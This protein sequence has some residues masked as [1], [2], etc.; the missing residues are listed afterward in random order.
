MM[1]RIHRFLLSVGIAGQLLSPST[2]LRAQIGHQESARQ[3][4]LPD[5]PSHVQGAGSSTTPVQ[6][7]SRRIESDAPWPRKADRGGETVLMYQPQIKSWVGEEISAYS[8]L[9]VVNNADKKTRY[10][11]VSFTARTE[12][13]KV[14]RQVALDNFQI[15]KLQFPT[16]K[17]REAEYQAFLQSK[18][19]AKTKVIALDRLE[20]ALAA[21]NAA[22]DIKGLPVNN[23]P[24]RIIFTTKP[25]LLVLID[26]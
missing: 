4:H 3:E 10:G 20:T 25:A 5:A 21:S 26:G 16:M 11:V 19:P 14:N 7:P 24:P 15:T 1:M 2:G 8:A 6:P 13:D 18:L 23:D 22:R 17:D 9:A 12:V